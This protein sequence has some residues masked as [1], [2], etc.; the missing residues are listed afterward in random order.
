MEVL[1]NLALI[2]VV[3]SDM[4]L[5]EELSGVECAIRIVAQIGAIC[6]SWSLCVEE[7]YC[8]VVLEDQ[9]ELITFLK[10]MNEDFCLERNVSKMLYLLV[11]LRFCLCTFSP[12]CLR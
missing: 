5:L 1:D 8:R 11:S 9:K 6:L 3:D 7:H 2:E 4:L 12:N 10:M